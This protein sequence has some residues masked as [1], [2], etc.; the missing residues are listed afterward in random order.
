[1][2]SRKRWRD[3]AIDLSVDLTKNLAE[4]FAQ[5]LS[6]FSPGMPWSYLEVGTFQGS[7]A[8]WMLDNVLSHPLSECYCVDV[9]RDMALRSNGRRFVRSGND[10]ELAARANLAKYGSKVIIVKGN[11]AEVLRTWQHGPHQII[12][13]DGDHGFAGCLAD[14]YASW[15]LLSPGG[16]VIWDDYSDGRRCQVKKAVQA[17]LETIAGRFDEIFKNS[18][19]F[20][21]RKTI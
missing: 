11:S 17:F 1:M 13:I 2:A 15:P 4:N 20:A 6:R 7:S 8:A 21:I 9:W 3:V 16:V 19:Q 18:W 5:Y 10:I 14:S 12:Y